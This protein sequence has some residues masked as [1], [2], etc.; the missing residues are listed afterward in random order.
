ME[1]EELTDQAKKLYSRQTVLK[2]EADRAEDQKNEAAQ[3]EMKQQTKAGELKEQLE[4]DHG[5]LESAESVINEAKISVDVTGAQER[6]LN[7]QATLLSQTDATLRAKQMQNET[8]ANDLVQKMQNRTLGRNLVSELEGEEANEEMQ[9]AAV[10]EMV[11]Q[12]KIESDK[13]SSTIHT[14]KKEFDSL[15]QSIRGVQQAEAQEAQ[16][17]AAGQQSQQDATQVARLAGARMSVAE[18]E[19][20]KAEKDA[21]RSHA[22]AS[23][24][25]QQ[26]K[27]AKQ[28][29]DEALIQA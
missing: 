26:M 13:L 7:E 23:K 15:E 14:E 4:D 2:N 29:A 11:Q 1:A 16:A 28:Q 19:A 10:S 6:E 5:E 12:G 18:T 25:V 21:L 27:S 20:A 3:R 9:T 17:V 22:R 24:L 8:L